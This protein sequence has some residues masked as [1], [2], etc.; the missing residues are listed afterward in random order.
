MLS[1]AV[2]LLIG[3]LVPAIVGEDGAPTWLGN[4][5]LVIGYGLLAW[6][7]FRAMQARRDDKEQGKS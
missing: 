7:F 3:A 4:A 1:G 2:I 6:G 5:T